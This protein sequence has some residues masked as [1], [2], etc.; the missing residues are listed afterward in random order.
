MSRDVNLQQLAQNTCTLSPS[1]L[2]LDAERLL[3]LRAWTL[4]AFILTALYVRPVSAP[5]AKKR[6]PVYPSF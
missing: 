2:R 5:F 1:C 4:N 6:K 3:W